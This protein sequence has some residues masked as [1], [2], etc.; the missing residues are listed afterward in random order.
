MECIPYG[1]E[2]SLVRWKDNFRTF[3]GYHQFKTEGYLQ[4]S[5]DITSIQR[6]N[7]FSQWRDIFS[8]LEDIQFIGRISSVY[9]G[10]ISSVSGGISSVRWRVFSTVEGYDQYNEEIP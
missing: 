10:G 4:C 8:K 7:I 1:G 2:I 9:N 3:E 6:R 5:R